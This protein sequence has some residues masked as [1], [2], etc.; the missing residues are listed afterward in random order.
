MNPEN[1]NFLI[2][3]DPILGAILGP[4]WAPK[5]IQNWLFFGAR[6]WSSFC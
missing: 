1:I 5:F 4:E 2:N 3:F 6:F